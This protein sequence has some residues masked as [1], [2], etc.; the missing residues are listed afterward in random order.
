MGLKYAP[1]WSFLVAPWSNV[2]FRSWNGPK[3]NQL[4]GWMSGFHETHKKINERGGERVASI[5]LVGH[6]DWL[7]V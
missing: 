6:E 3:G 5:R 2:N 7:F 1:R 4:L